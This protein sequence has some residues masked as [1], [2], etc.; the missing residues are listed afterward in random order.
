MKLS[1]EEIVARLRD[2][3][4]GCPWDLQQDHAS[5]APHFV[6][7]VYEVLDA[8]DEGDPD[9][10]REELGDVLFQ[11]VFHCQLAG[12]RGSF[13]LADV[14]AGIA[15]KMVAR[16]PHVFG[17]DSGPPGDAAWVLERWEAGKRRRRAERGA[18]VLDGVP[19]QLPALQRAQ[20]LTAKASVVGFDWPDV[21]S[22]LDKVDEELAEVRQAM[23]SGDADAVA[24]E[25]G[26]LL[27][28]VVNL[29]RKV[30]VDAEQALRGTNRK[31][32]DRFTHIETQLAARGSSPEA[33]SL[34]EMDALWNDAKYAQ[35][36]RTR[37]E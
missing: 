37:P 14:E 31:F 8:I 11:I 24:D 36:G 3:Q 7:E 22:V 21:P 33:A 13:T 10:L 1:L 25:V 9:A 17:E 2:P 35:T 26:D 29:A 6:E 16:H 20:R 5:M 4:T 32:C 23:A 12:E 34:G 18:S 28:A 27:F 19:R 30:G 15:T